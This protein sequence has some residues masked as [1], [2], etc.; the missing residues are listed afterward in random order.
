MAILM[1]DVSS[2]QPDS[3]NW[4]RKLADLGVKAVVVKL[5]EG[6]GY[7]NPKAAAQIAAGRKV[8]MHVHAYHYAHY[9]NSAEAVA[10][11]RF[12]ALTARALGVPPQ[13][14]MVAD[15]E[16][17]ELTGDLTGLTNVFI[18]TVK[19][20]GYPHTDLYTMANWMKTGRFDRVALIPK[21][22]W[23]ASYG[24]NQPGIDNVGTWQFTNNFHGLGV[25]MSYDFFGHYT[26]R[27]SGQ[28]NGAVARVPTVH[29][30]TVQA[31]ESWWAI[32]HRFGMNMD[33]LAALN[34]KT[35]HSV[36]HPVDQLRLN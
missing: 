14:V 25:D 7:Q 24:V 32:A 19:S 15:V 21:N 10:E 16:A 4:F 23:I 31:G 27:L 2:W 12:F 11:G 9:R 22:L 30:H 13:S 35:I 29:Y 5:T 34:G 36:I 26:T 6:T 18:Q 33:K 28:L 20:L 3:E 1:A 8:G 17:P